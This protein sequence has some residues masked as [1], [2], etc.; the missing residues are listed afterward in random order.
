MQD[1]INKLSCKNYTHDVNSST[2][3]NGAP[4]ILFCGN[5]QYAGKV[6][7]D[8]ES[9]LVHIE[10]LQRYQECIPG[11][12]ESVFEEE[13]CFDESIELLDRLSRE[14]SSAL[15]PVKLVSGDA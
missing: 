13:V 5:L 15:L 7:E 11:S 9:E 2:V 10:S 14:L 1:K 6:L 3:P 8:L 4:D 12:P